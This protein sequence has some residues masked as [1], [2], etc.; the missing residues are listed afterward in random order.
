MPV[1]KFKVETGPDSPFSVGAGKQK[2]L[3]KLDGPGVLI[4]IYYTITQRTTEL[5][6][7]ADE[8]QVD[9]PT[10]T[11]LST[12]KLT[13][14]ATLGYA[15]M[16]IHEYNSTTPFGF[17]FE[18]PV[19]FDSLLEFVISNEAAATATLGHYIVLWEKCTEQA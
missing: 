12:M 4:A 1:K 3:L 8:E 14:T 5:Q 2:K 11:K 18:H 16:K 19:E 15:G 17:A 13:Q 6:L 10:L 9:L 7:I